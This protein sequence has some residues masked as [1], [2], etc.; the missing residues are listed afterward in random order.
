MI[1]KRCLQLATHVSLIANCL[2]VCRYDSE[3][4]GTTSG[5]KIMKKLGILID[6][7]HDCDNPDGKLSRITNSQELLARH[8]V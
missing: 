7:N 8:L 1:E 2:L 6:K 3:G 4:I 5:E